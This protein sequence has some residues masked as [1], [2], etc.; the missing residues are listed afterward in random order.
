L[1]SA[2]QVRFG[3]ADEG[4]AHLAKQAA[5]EGNKPM[6]FKFGSLAA[7]KRSNL[8]EAIQEAEFA[9]RSGDSSAETAAL[10]S[11]L[12]FRT[13]R[14]GK[15]R[16][17]A[18][19]ALQAN[20]DQ[21]IPRELLVLSWLVLFPPFL[22]AHLC[23]MVITYVQKSTK[24]AILLALALFFAGA[25]IILA[26]FWVTSGLMMPLGL[27][28]WPTYALFIAFC[29]YSPYI[30]SVA[31]LLTRRRKELKLSGY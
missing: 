3:K 18:R 13:L 11:M 14:L 20:H 10:L 15:C 21:P 8:S 30:G 2:Y 25:P 7:V 4:F 9:R 31:K 5:R 12:C 23:L 29:L 22:L 26:V 28:G 16:S 17:Y 6:E 27:D 1:E 19:L 24:F